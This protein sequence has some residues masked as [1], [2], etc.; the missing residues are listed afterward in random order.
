M[1][2]HNEANHNRHNDKQYS[3]QNNTAD[4]FSIQHALLLRLWNHLLSESVG[5]GAGV[6][7]DRAASE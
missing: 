4:L 6:G 2:P 3:H 7:G 5:V 1:D